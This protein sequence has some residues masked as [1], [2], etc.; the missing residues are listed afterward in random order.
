MNMKK[1]L[2]AA[3]FLS[4]AIGA[5]ASA[6]TQDFTILNNTGYPIEQ[7]Y[8][9]ASA[10]DNWEEDVLGQDILSDGDRTKIRFNRDEDA[11]LWDLKVV[12]SDQE[13]AEWQGINLCKVSVVALSYDR[14]SGRTSAETE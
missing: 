7:V 1:L 5:P 10:K 9:S 6:A 14:K 2:L 4:S 13:S 8:V 11:C 12:Y 3:A